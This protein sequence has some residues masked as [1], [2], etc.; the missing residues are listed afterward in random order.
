M[1]LKHDPAVDITEDLL[2]AI[3]R[4]AVRREV[5]HCGVRIEIDPFD[6]YAECPQCRT[7]MK[8]RS[9]S[10]H[11]EIEDVFDAVFEWMNVFVAEEVARRR[12]AAI[13]ADE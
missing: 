1:D 8:V 11:Y 12:Q 6:F 9:F 7:R 5:E 3:R 2:D 4:F 13:A 10:G